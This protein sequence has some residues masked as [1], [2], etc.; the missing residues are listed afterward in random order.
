MR[1]SVKLLVAVATLSGLCLG[2]HVAAT[3]TQSSVAELFRRMQTSKTDDEAARKL[4]QLGSSDPAARRYL[5]SH[6][7][8]AVGEGPKYSRER[9][10]PQPQWLDEV[11]LAGELRLREAVPALAKWIS[12]RT[13]NSNIVS[14]SDESNLD[15][16]PVAAALA[17]IGDAAVPALREILQ[18]GNFDQRSRAIYTLKLIG[19]PKAKA[20]LREHAV[21]ES[22]PTLRDIIRR[23]TSK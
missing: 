8:P 7:P 9:P 3:Q 14:L 1:S 13:G 10:G 18:R 22:D 15:N 16:S 5:A 2:N 21:H 6:L 12:V 19:S 20:V 11:R 23:A 4:L 17:Q